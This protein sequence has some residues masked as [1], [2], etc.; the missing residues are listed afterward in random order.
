MDRVSR[1]SRARED[2]SRQDLGANIIRVFIGYDSRESIAY[3][4]LTQSI[5]NQTTVPV[6]IAPLA[7]G[8]S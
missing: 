4:V 8:M 5:I 2:R 6:S 1:L 3:H 7:E